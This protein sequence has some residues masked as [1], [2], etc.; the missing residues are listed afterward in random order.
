MARNDDSGRRQV[1]DASERAEQ[2]AAERGSPLFNELKNAQWLKIKE[3]CEIEVAI[4]PYKVKY[5][6]RYNQP[7]DY[8]YTREYHVHSE[9]GI[10][11]D[12][13]MLCHQATFGEECAVCTAA[14]KMTR[15]TSPS[16]RAAAA[17]VA[18]AKKRNLYRM[19]IIG[20]EE[21]GLFV[22]DAS[23]YGFQQLLEE[24]LRSNRAKQLK[25]GNFSDNGKKGFNLLLTFAEKAIGAKANAKSGKAKGASK[26]WFAVT[27]IEFIPRDAP[28]YEQEWY[29]AA[30]N[31]DKL[32]K[33]HTVEEQEAEFAAIGAASDGDDSRRRGSED[34]DE[35]ARPARRAKP[36]A[37][38]DDEEAP[39]PS[40]K[41][42]AAPVDEDED[43]YPQPPRKATKRPVA[44]ED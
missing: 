40:A 35:D 6:T 2:T 10:D 4:V 13:R 28:A 18:K 9:L 5:A 14:S 34:D 22:L 1:R 37:D 17:T 27:A 36:A 11:G 26:P 30:P 16:T 44:D 15:S 12:R 23:Y 21:E 38:E 33:K 39:A 7:G 8:D 29:D 32:L 20:R 31:L 42:K 43:D 25:W 3:R 19:F 41:R 24:R